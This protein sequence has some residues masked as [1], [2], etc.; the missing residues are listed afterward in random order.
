MGDLQGNHFR[1]DNLEVNHRYD[2]ILGHDIYLELNI[3]LHSFNNTAKGNG[4]AYKECIALI[5][6]VSKLS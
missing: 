4:S 6:Y 3:Y 5:K 1:A 2:M